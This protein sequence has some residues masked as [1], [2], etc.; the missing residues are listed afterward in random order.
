MT[1][2]RN[3]A[4]KWLFGA[5][6]VLAISMGA[7]WPTWQSFVL[8]AICLALLWWI[9]G[10]LPGIASAQFLAIKIPPQLALLVSSTF[11][12]LLLAE[13]GLRLF[14]T[15]DF[16]QIQDEKNLMYRYD[17]GLGW[18]PIPGSQRTI[19]RPTQTF[20]AVHNS[21][22]FRDREFAASQ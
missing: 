13:I 3:R 7:L 2:Q 9:A 6:V 8:L 22:G 15:S 1:W 14:W 5:G 11:L 16:P 21:L 18:F 10:C 19:R 17:E 12:S 20:T 4:G